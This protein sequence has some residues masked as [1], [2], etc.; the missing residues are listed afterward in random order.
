MQATGNKRK[1]S[2]RSGAAGVWVALLSVL[3][4]CLCATVASAASPKPATDKSQATL[5]TSISGEEMMA[6]LKEMGFAP[7]LSKDPDGDPLIT[8]QIEGITN[9]IVF[10]DGTNGR[11]ESIQFFTGSADKVPLQKVNEWNQKKRF[12][13]VYLSSDGTINMDWN[14]ALSGGVPKEYLEQALLRWKGVLMGYLFFFF[15]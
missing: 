4:M 8:F 10:Y 9:E 13:R 7:E 1:Y 2:S 15:Q 12:G 14:V 5:Y 6:I 3:V 11:Y